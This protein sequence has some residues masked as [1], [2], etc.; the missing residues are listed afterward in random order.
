MPKQQDELDKRYLA[1]S[2]ADV[3]E[4]CTPLARTFHINHFNYRRTYT[5]GKRITL[6]N[7]PRWLEH[8][9][10]AGYN[11]TPTFEKERNESNSNRLTLWTELYDND[12]FLNIFLDAKNNFN[13][14]QGFTITEVSNDYIELYHFAGDSQF[15]QNTDYFVENLDL[16]QHFIRYFRDKG[17]PLIEEAKAHAAISPMTPEIITET[18]GF[19]NHLLRDPQKYRLAHK[20]DK[21]ELQVLTAR[22]TECLAYSIM[23]YPMRE[24][25]NILRISP[26]TIECHLNALKLKLKC[27]TKKDVMVNAKNMPVVEHASMKKIADNFYDFHATSSLY[28]D[29]YNNYVQETM[30]KRLYVDTFSENLY[31]TQ[32]EAEVLFYFLNGFSS[33]Q[34][35]IALNCSFRTVEIYLTKLKARFKI[36]KSYQLIK[37][38]LDIGLHVK[39]AHA[40]PYL[41]EDLLVG[42][43]R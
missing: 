37:H 36:S 3:A 12:F 43:N 35:G 25:A 9:Y 38:C 14:D 27:Y 6:T 40:F 18:R 33:K 8:Y 1:Q 2:S 42:E 29:Q 41:I 24:I 21:G 20:D 34:I 31:L 32:R 23:Q 22:E 5:D 7:D 19:E 17:Q 28:Q 15:H 39:I 13:I 16:L 10:E 30:V 11:V 4:L 26:R